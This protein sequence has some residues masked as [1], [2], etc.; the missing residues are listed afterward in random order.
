MKELGGEIVK[1]QVDAIRGN[2][3]HGSVHIRRDGKIRA[4]DARPSD[5]IALA[6][7]NRVPIYVAQRVL[8]ESGMSIEELMRQ[9]GGAP[10]PGGP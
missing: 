2:T 6:I 7:G 8:D 9:A 4:L 3:F 10:A 1:V 5:A